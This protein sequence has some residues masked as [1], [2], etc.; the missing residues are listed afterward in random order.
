M[1]KNI[2]INKYIDYIKKYKY[3]ILTLTAIILVFISISSIYNYLKI[4]K[5]LGLK[6]VSVAEFLENPVYDKIVKIYGEA[7]YFG[8]T[9][10]FRQTPD[11]PCFSLYSNGKALNIWHDGMKI[12]GPIERPSA[13][14]KEVKNGANVIVIGELKSESKDVEFKDFWARK[15]EKLR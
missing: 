9:N 12:F 4:R 1:M 10:Q 14:T 3:I 13:D 7:S 6:A 2:E 11:C 5:G 15:I 8:E